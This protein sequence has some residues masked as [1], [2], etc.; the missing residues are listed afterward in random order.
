M[1]ASKWMLF[2]ALK[3]L[4]ML[5]L[6][7]LKSLYAVISTIKSSQAHGKWNPLLFKISKF[8][9]IPVCAVSLGRRTDFAIECDVMERQFIGHTQRKGDNCITGNAMQWNPFSQDDRRVSRPK[10]TYRRTVKGC[11]RLAKSW[12]ELKCISG[13]RV[14]VWFTH[15]TSRRSEQQQYIHM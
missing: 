2:D 15:Y 4:D 9:S 5:S 8:S 7:C 11:R 13:D 14:L 10:N 6:P 3:A 1:V 12:G